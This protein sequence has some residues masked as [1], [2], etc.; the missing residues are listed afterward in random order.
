[1]QTIP[2]VLWTNYK[3]EQGVYQGSL[4]HKDSYTKRFLNQT[5]EAISSGAYDVAKLRMVLDGIVHL[6]TTVASGR[7][8]QQ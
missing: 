2:R 7:T 1:M 8:S 3:K 5:P 4:E 6:C